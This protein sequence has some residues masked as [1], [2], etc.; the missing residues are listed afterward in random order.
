VTG[1]TTVRMT[2][3]G[4]D[5]PSIAFLRTENDVRLEFRLVAR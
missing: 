5:P 1:R 3:F 4:F 2:D